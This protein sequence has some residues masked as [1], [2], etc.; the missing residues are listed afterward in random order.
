MEGGSPHILRIPCVRVGHLPCAP[1][2]CMQAL[3]EE[4]KEQIR[5]GTFEPVGVRKPRCLVREQPSPFC[6]A[7]VAP[8]TVGWAAARF[9]VGAPLAGMAMPPRVISALAEQPFL[10]WPQHATPQ[11]PMAG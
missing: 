6:G 9:T 11:N 2:P 5:A 7:R 8:C 4:M 10:C 3:E 1:L